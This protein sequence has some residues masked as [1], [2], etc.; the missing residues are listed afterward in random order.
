LATA[1]TDGD[2]RD[3]VLCDALCEAATIS[4]LLLVSPLPLVP[5]TILN[6]V[7]VGIALR[8]SLESS[9]GLFT[10][11][12]MCYEE[13]KTSKDI[14]VFPMDSE[15]CCYPYPYHDLLRVDDPLYIC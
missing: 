9:F 1:V 7:L 14:P 6:H 5:F 11:S 10:L 13:G 2:G 4:C 12:I 8:T 3:T 15:E